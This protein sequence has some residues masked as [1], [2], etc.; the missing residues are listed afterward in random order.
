MRPIFSYLCIILG[1]CALV[2]FALQCRGLYQLHFV[3]QETLGK[4]VGSSVEERYSEGGVAPGD[5]SVG[6]YV[7]KPQ[8]IYEYEVGGRQYRG[9][10]FNVSE[11]A[12]LKKWAE[13]I[14]NK[15]P[16]DAKI[17]VFFN[18]E[19]P[20]RSVL[21]KWLPFDYYVIVLLGSLVIGVGCIGGSLYALKRKKYR[22]VAT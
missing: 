20:E 17:T 15:Y 9:T 6:G 21:T 11:S 5:L 13:E 18:P 10:R 14:V 12:R 16:V 2:F 8:V 3:F 22:I 4:I 1:I 19:K 7:Y